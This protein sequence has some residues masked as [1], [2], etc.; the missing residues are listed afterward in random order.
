MTCF[1]ANPDGRAVAIDGRDERHDAVAV[2]ALGGRACVGVIAPRE[3]RITRTV[4][5][6]VIVNVLGRIH[7]S[8]IH[9]RRLRGTD[10]AR[11]PCGVLRHQVGRVHLRGIV[12]VERIALSLVSRT[13][14][15][16]LDCN[17]KIRLCIGGLADRP[18]ARVAYLAIILVTKLVSRFVCRRIAAQICARAGI[19]SVIGTRLLRVRRTASRAA[20][21]DGGKYEQALRVLNGRGYG[22]VLGILGAVSPI[23][24][25]R[26]IRHDAPGIGSVQVV[27]LI[28]AVG[29]V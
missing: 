22:E 18:I 23:A 11:L 10:V 7:K 26:I 9:A 24:T 29:V 25:L 4:R 8:Q 20:A 15:V 2:G 5:R 3:S 12:M 19:G 14:S 1:A 13:Q 28:V 27:D 21:D 6:H 17:G 16:V